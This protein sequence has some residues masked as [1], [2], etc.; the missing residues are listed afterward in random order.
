MQNDFVFVPISVKDNRGCERLVGLACDLDFDKFDKFH[1]D[2][3]GK[4]EWAKVP[5]ALLADL[6]SFSWCLETDAFGRLEIIGDGVH[7]VNFFCVF[8]K[9]IPETQFIAPIEGRL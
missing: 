9:F 3:I 4:V 1:T 7:A 5:T 8:M 6:P 2:Y